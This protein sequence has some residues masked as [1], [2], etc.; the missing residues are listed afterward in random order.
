MKEIKIKVPDNQAELF[1][2]KLS[3]LIKECGGN[4]GD[5]E[6]DLY[7]TSAPRTWNTCASTTRNFRSTIPR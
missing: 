6:V 3:A 5:K 1:A 2:E 7:D 4:I